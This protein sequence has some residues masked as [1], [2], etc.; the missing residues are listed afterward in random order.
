MVMTGGM[1]VTDTSNGYTVE[2]TYRVFKGN[3]LMHFA[4]GWSERRQLLLADNRTPEETV[5]ERIDD[6]FPEGK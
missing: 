5:R 6:V 2:I 3:N 4:S 1:N